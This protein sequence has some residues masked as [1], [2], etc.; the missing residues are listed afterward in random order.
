MKKQLFLICCV[1]FDVFWAAAA[2]AHTPV[3]LCEE[4]DGQ[5]ECRGLFSDMSSAAGASILVKNDAG[6]V[7]LTGK[8]DE[9]GEWSFEIPKVHYTVTMDAGA[10]H[11][12]DPWD[13]KDME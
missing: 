11:V 12:T 7:I 4:D 1:A 6:K 9:Y 5:C 8:L 10:G 13:P 3:L 2:Y